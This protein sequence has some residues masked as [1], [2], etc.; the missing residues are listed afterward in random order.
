MKIIL[1]FPTIINPE[2]G[3][4]RTP[5]LG[6]S[7]LG[8]VLK[9]KGHKVKLIDLRLPK[10]TQDYFI[11]VLKS[12]KPDIVG[13]S[14]TSYGY[15]SGKE[16]FALT[17]KYYPKTVTI[18]G[19]PHAAVGGMNAIKDKNLDMFAIGEGE[20]LIIDLLDAIKNKKS[21]KDIKGLT[22]KDKR[23]RV[24]V[25]APRFNSSDLDALPFPQFNLLPIEEYRAGG[26]LTIPI[27][28]SRGCPFGCIYCVSW[29]TQGKM[30]RGRSAKNVVDEIEFLTRKI[31]VEH[32]TILDDNFAFDRKRA[33]E[34]CNE[35]IRRGLKIKW[36]CDQG[37][38]A[39]RTDYEVYKSMKD[40]GCTLIALGVE[41][42]DPEVLKKMN[43]GETIEDIKKSIRAAQKVGL[44]VKAFFIV[45]CPGDNLK[46]VKKSIKFFKDMNIDIPRYSMMTAYPGSVLW[47]WAEK[48]GRFLSDPFNYTVQRHDNSRDV[49]FE[50]DDF[51]AK[52]RL[53]GMRLASDEAEKWIIRFKLK[54]KFG[55]KFGLLL[56][57]LFKTDLVHHFIKKLYQMKLI[58]VVD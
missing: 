7:Y 42:P 37:I 54:N 3:L 56:Y 52:D 32:F 36:Q 12:F 6:I 1:I 10:Y 18:L 31:N 29:K 8:T 58:R 2:Y 43:K 46:L 53:K 21:L 48:N 38:R 5:P 51:R 16:I 55:E 40:S 35:I 9:K 26:T 11:K 20:D 34:I 24:H 57:P 39:D 30:F 15:L 13:V 45:G 50:T 4:P 27:M 14:A 23:G 47:A 44:I 33:I 19:G 22:Y 49:Q 17:K 41:N 25:N 28:T